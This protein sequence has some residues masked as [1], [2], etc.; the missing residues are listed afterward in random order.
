MT[1]RAWHAKSKAD[2]D[3]LAVLSDCSYQKVEQSVANLLPFDDC[4]VW[5]VDQYRGVTSKIDA[6]FAIAKSITEKQLADFFLLAELVLSEADPALDLPEDKR[7]A[8]GL[9]G[10]VRDHSAALREGICE[11][12]VILSV[13]GNN[14]FRARLGIDVDA[15]VSHL[16]SKLLTPLTLEKLL[17][18][19][20]DL[21]RY[22]EAAPDG[23][24][25]LIEEDLSQTEPVVLGLLKPAGNAI[26]GGCPRTGLLWGL[27]C[28]AWNP[29][30]L[31]R[32]TKV[33]AQLSRTRIADNWI[34][35]PIASLEALYRAWM[36]QTAATV[37][38]RAK[39]L[40]MLTGSFPDIAWQICVEQ[41]GPGSQIGHFS[42]R[43]RWRDDAAGAGQPAKQHEYFKFVRK[44]LDLALAWPK[45]DETTL[46][47]LVERLQAIPEKDQAVVWDLVDAW[48]NSAP[49]AHA[50]SALRERIRRY[51]FT[52]RGKR[53]VAQKIRT[54]A[55]AAY[56]ALAP[57][58]PVIRHAWLFANQWVDESAEELE[59][60]NIDFSKREER[61]HKLRTSAMKEIWAR[62]GFDGIEALLPMTGAPHIV[63]RYV[64]GCVS[65]AKE[66]ANVL[67]RCLAIGGDRERLADS[68]LQGFL[69][70]L[71]PALRAEIL[72]S[73]AGNGEAA[74]MVRL[75]RCA[76][77]GQETWRLLDQYDDDIKDRYWLEVYPYWGRQTDEELNELTDRLL[78]ARRPRAA[79]H[80]VHMD[81]PR[82]ETSRL[83]R[84]LLA[85]ATV[86]DEPAGRF[87]FNE[88]DISAALQSLDGRAGVSSDELAHLEFM[89]IGA[90]SH[91]KRGIPHLERQVA[92]SPALY[93]QAMALLY[94][95]SDGGED[96]AEWRI[97]DSER[98]TAAATAALRLL[99]HVKRIPGTDRDGTIK[100]DSLI[101]WITEVR[102]LCVQ[103]GRV[104]VGDHCIGQLLSRAPAEEDGVWPCRPVCEAMEKIASPDI[105]DGFSIGTRNA[106]GAHW[107]GEGGAQERELVA[108]Y[109]AWA[110]QLRFNFTYVS[111]VLDRIADSYDREAVWQDS[112]TA[113]SKRLRT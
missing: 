31:P 34:N 36:P 18:Q 73:V 29:G 68:C 77:F 111:S 15:R 103:H 30:N 35:K 56:D 104:K 64:A 69:D 27:E 2:C 28:L 5:S 99:D 12:L 16:V 67:R 112:Q 95:R 98:R 24:L 63:G 47:D 83:K 33:L 4:P 38:D 32:V 60:E 65:G 26:F 17:S 78:D 1:T 8:A 105:A 11:T 106:R 19:D 102:Q 91:G 70:A 6:L 13:H 62:C 43:P 96:P 71:N 97:E 92:E 49:D 74:S 41:F 20:R 85:V 86:D 87:Q 101:A 79:F 54:R 61:I 40:E 80:T 100:A 42:Y 90:L 52:R 76:P 108:K 107:R 110:Q 84:L 21:P 55:R 50:M 14:L 10:K 109:R 75:Y 82:I 113:L 25:R 22:A 58:D 59:D 44:A 94:K 23:F 51:A 72:P 66:S 7:W 81:W 93:M 3:I 46:G 48:S 53:N 57:S 88:H 9:Y 89:F 39:S 45:H 37:E